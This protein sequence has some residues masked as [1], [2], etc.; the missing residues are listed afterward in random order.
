MNVIAMLRTLAESVAEGER[1]SRHGVGFREKLRGQELENQRAQIENE[2]LP[3]RLKR[4]GKI[5]E[6]AL[7]AEEERQARR[8]QLAKLTG[9]KDA[10]PEAIAGLEASQ[11]EE[12]RKAEMARLNAQT[13]D[14][15][16]AAEGRRQAL[17]NARPNLSPVVLDEV[18]PKWSPDSPAGPQPGP[19]NM[20]IGLITDKRKEEARIRAAAA[21]RQ[22]SF[23]PHA[24]ASMI[25]D[26]ANRYTAGEL[27]FEQA[28][29][30]LGGVKGMQVNGPAFM[31]AIGE[32][33]GFSPQIRKDLGGIQ[34]T[35][36]IVDQM[37][38]LMGDIINAK[39]PTERAKATMLLEQ[40]GQ[41]TGTLLSRGFGE[42]GV[43]TDRDVARATGL[44]PGWKAANFAPEYA[45]RE[46]ALLREVLDRN[47]KG[48]V[49][50][51]VSVR[52]RQGNIIP[53]GGSGGSGGAVEE[54]VRDPVT[55][56]LVLKPRAQ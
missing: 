4:T 48:L 50:A 53:S 19:T 2:D 40:F 36:N 44:V 22:A 32:R 43:V 11:D 42:R 26:L 31:S 6:I 52:D 20:E 14:E 21:G 12:K 27:T 47:E 5:Q 7:T 54:Y 41:T 15:I 49:E 29:G 46:I 51:N 18:F 25:E 16:A 55:K 13:D 1:I 17:P 38:G 24:P 35:R 37:E 23:G 9:I 45:A 10:T 28:R 8:L 56:K 39:D 3:G 30:A 34:T 33:R